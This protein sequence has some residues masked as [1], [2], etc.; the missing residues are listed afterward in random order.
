MSDQESD[1]GVP[2]IR[3]PYHWTNEETS[4][5]HTAYR[6]GLSI[7]QLSQMSGRSPHHVVQHLAWTV[8]GVSPADV[9]ALAPRFRQPWSDSEAACLG[10]WW[11]AGVGIA[12]LAE[13]LDRDVTEVAE[14]IIL[15]RIV[16]DAVPRRDAVTREST[17]PA[18][19]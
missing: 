18:G 2:F 17:S 10:T 12:D 9:N 6:S 15:E 5:L 13:R 4:L 16:R 14:R 3:P 8:L 11:N 7:R 19:G 1:I